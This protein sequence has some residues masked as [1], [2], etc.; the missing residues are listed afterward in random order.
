[1]SF[2]RIKYFLTSQTYNVVY[3]QALMDDVHPSHYLLQ[4]QVLRC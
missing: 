4:S 3:S 2:E 1:M